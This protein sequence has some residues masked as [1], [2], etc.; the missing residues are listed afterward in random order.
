MVAEIHNISNIHITK[1]FINILSRK[2]TGFHRQAKL[3]F[4][5]IIIIIIIKQ[6][7]LQLETL[8]LLTERILYLHI[9]ATY[10][11]LLYLHYSTSLYLLQHCSDWFNH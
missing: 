3:F 6:F 4:F 2:A 9:H 11:T 8:T 5:F 7:Y 1:G 10:I